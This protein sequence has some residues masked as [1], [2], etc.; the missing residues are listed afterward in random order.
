MKNLFRF[1]ALASAS[2]T[3]GLSAQASG[4]N[5]G[6]LLVYPAFDNIRGD[7]TLLTVVNTND[8]QTNGTVKVEFVYINQHN[9]Q[10]FNRTRTLTPNDCLTVVT[11]YDNPNQVKGYAYVFAKDKTSGKAI[12]FN[13]LIGTERV[14]SA[15]DNDYEVQPWVFESPL[16]QGANTDL[17]NGVGDGIRDL[18]GAE[19]GQAPDRVLIPRFIGQIPGTVESELILIGLTGGSEFDT[20][21]DF[22]IYNDNEEEFS[23]QR[24]FDCYERCWLSNISG[25]FDHSFLVTTNHNPLEVVGLAPNQTLEVG[26]MRLNGLVASSSATSIAQ[27]AILAALVEHT[28]LGS[29]VV[30]PWA[31]G[32]QNNGDLIPHSVFGDQ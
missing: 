5:P 7:I 2:L 20:L 30:M 32:E 11:K 8:D 31:V 22:L 29:G 4:V 23:A 15:V 27:P 26:W 16:A 24:S 21:V 9:C 25:A 18:D 14:L 3:L 6:S 10:E 13:H 17:E 12:S 28:P 19:Y 1:A